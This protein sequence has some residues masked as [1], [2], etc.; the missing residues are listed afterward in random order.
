LIALARVLAGDARA[1]DI[2][3]DAMLVAYDK[4]SEVSR[5]GRPGRS[6]A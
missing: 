6:R 2:G 4:W 1:Q 5:Y 3:Q